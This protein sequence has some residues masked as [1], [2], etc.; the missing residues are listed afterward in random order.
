MELLKKT[1][2]SLLFQ[3]YKAATFGHENVTSPA[4]SL[5]SVSITP[6]ERLA[7]S[8][9]MDIS[10]FVRTRES[11]GLIFYLGTPP[12]DSGGPSYIAA[13]L[14]AGRL[15]VVADLGDGEQLFP[16]EET[17]MLNDGNS[18]LIQVRKDAAIPQLFG[19]AF[20]TVAFLLVR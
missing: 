14:Q 6:Q 15:L 12:A 2:F 10:M 19:I 20:L 7:L 3:G 16:V 17:P 18:H 11:S 5:V 8:N 4:N 1:C 9:S 13:E